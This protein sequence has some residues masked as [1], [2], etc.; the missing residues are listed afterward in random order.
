VDVTVRK[1]INEC[2]AMCVGVES[3]TVGK[4]VD[5]ATRYKTSR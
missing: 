1:N 5:S 4:F 3:V 2:D